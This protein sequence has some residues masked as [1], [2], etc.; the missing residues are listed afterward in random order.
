MKHYQRLWDH[1]PSL[2]ILGCVYVFV[3]LSELLT[4][5]GQCYLAPAFMGTSMGLMFVLFSA[6]FFGDCGQVVRCCDVPIVRQCNGCVTA[7]CTMVRCCLKTLQNSPVVRM[8]QMLVIATPVTPQKPTPYVYLGDGGLLENSGALELLRREL[9]LI[10]VM[11]AG[12]DPQMEMSVLKQLI[13][14]ARD[15]KICSFYVVDDNIMSVDE[16]IWRHQQDDTETFLEL[17]ILY[18]LGSDADTVDRKTGNLIWVQNRPTGPKDWTKQR[19]CQRFVPGAEDAPGANSTEKPLS[20][21]NSCCWDGRCCFPC[22]TFPNIN[23][24]QQFFSPKMA[25]NFIKFGYLLSQE[26]VEKVIEIRMRHRA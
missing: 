17:G 18:G 6:A 19:Q 3:G 8:I 13:C 22:G 2:L 24:A 26:A 10:L 14:R 15:E 5:P 16:R 21:L 23:T 20:E 9:P 25:A 4:S 12:D 11:E 7:V 1:L